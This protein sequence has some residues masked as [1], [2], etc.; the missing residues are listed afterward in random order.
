MKPGAFLVNT[1]RGAI[2]NEAELIA[3]LTTRLLAGAGLDVMTQ[4]PLPPTSPLCALPNVILQP[5]AAAATRETRRAME[6]RAV[7]NLLGVLCGRQTSVIVNPEAL[8]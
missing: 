4:E 6:E 2:V 8:S 7:E 1:A 5:H 3:A